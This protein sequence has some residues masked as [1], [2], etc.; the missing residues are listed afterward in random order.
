M[1]TISRIIM[2]LLVAAVVAGAF[3]LAVKDSSSA[4]STNQGSNPSDI[5]N[6]QSFQPVERP[7]GSD[8]DGGS[9]TSGLAGVLGTAVKLTGIAIV[10]LL[11]QKGFSLLGNRR[12]LSTH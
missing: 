7:G 6:G 12:V 4:S 3:T 5:T 2:I 11:L 10:V 1:K 9:L 8:R